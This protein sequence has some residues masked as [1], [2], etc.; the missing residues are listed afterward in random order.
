MKASLAAWLV[1]LY[2]RRWRER[3]GEEFMAL[4]EHERADVHTLLNTIGSAAAEHLLDRSRLGGLLVQTYPATVLALARKPSA[5]L[6]LA[7][8]LVAIALV[9]GVVAIYGVVKDPDEGTAAHIWQL[10]MVGQLPFLA[11]FAIKWLPRERGAAATVLAINFVAVLAAAAP[12][13]FLG[14]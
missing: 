12:V 2:P 3:F 13:W 7:M 5:F 6:P 10:L 14:L 1:R 8:S 9:A 4:L 11:I